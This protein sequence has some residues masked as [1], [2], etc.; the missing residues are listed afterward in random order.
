MMGTSRYFFGGSFD[1]LLDSVTGTACISEGTVCRTVLPSAST[2][3]PISRSCR[4]SA[5]PSP[6]NHCG[7]RDSGLTRATKIA[8][9]VKKLRDCEAAVPRYSPFDA[10]YEVETMNGINVQFRITEASVIVP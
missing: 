7:R 2:T 4:V 6:C 8:A 9:D 10:L 3:T 5:P 1:E